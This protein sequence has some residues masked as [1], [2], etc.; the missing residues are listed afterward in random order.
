MNPTRTLTAAAV[1]AALSVA[2]AVP[3]QAQQRDR[4]N[5]GRSP[6]PDNRGR[7][8]ER[9]RP[10]ERGTSGD[11]ARVEP[12][13]QERANGDRQYRD[14]PRAAVPR[15]VVPQ[16]QRYDRERRGDEQQRYGYRSD[17]Y[18]SYG[19]R[20]DS[21]TFR[22]RLRI[23]FGVYLG[24]PVAYPAYD[25]Y[26]YP[27]TYGY[28]SQAGYAGYGGV[29]LEISPSNAAVYVDGQYAG[30]VNDFYYPSRPL[31]LWAGRHRINVQAPGYQ[32]LEFDVNIVPGE[33]LPYQGSL[34]LF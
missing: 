16:G 3:A 30:V 18:R 8:V 24:Y 29:S 11:R 33:V 9:A 28:P 6:G 21:Y 23:A 1:L 32:P 2:A 4:G 20:P 26:A 7:A 14:T 10:V 17:G 22:P 15:A 27:P 5:Q 13:R 19:Y 34:A 12:P 31:S 25:P